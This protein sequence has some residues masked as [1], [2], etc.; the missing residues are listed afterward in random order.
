MESNKLK[1][2]EYLKIYIRGLKLFRVLMPWYMTR[3]AVTALCHA[4]RP[5]LTLALSAR[6]LDELAGAR[7]LKLIALYAALAVG[8][9]FAL[10]ALSVAL[11]RVNMKDGDYG[12]YRAAYYMAMTHRAERFAALDFEHAESSAVNEKLSEI[13]GYENWNSYGLVFLFFRVPSLMKATLS[14]AGSLA[15]LAGMIMSGG[16]SIATALLLLSPIVPILA[17]IPFVRAQE[18]LNAEMQKTMPKA[19]SLYGYF[20]STYIHPDK[21][22]KDIRIFNQKAAVMERLDRL[23]FKKSMKAA[24]KYERVGNAAPSAINAALGAAAYL[25]IGLKALA[26]AFTIGQVTQYVG[27][28]T[29]FTQ[30]VGQCASIL[31]ELR[32][33]APFLVMLYE[34]LDLPDVKY[35]GTLTTEKRADNEYEIEF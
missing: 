3:S 35:R 6:L 30:S 15:L 19:N 24:Y 11:S 18:R 31:T 25:V 2:K 5:L 16:A 4:A 21:A 12:G 26:G 7:D 22:G 9:G 28:L 20:L 23:E 1:L 34:F 14:V 27:A 17:R 8:A 29:S 13:R 10:L 32:V 33:N